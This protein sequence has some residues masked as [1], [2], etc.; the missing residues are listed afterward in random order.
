[1][2]KPCTIAFISLPLFGTSFSCAGISFPVRTTTSL[3]T[4]RTDNV[5]FLTFVSTFSRSHFANFDVNCTSS[6]SLSRSQPPSPASK[7]LDVPVTVLCHAVQVRDVEGRL[8]GD[9][10][11][12][13][14]PMV[15]VVVEELELGTVVRGHG[16]VGH[17]VVEELELG[18]VVRGHGVVGD[19]VQF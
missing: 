19:V 1:M 3:K 5:N 16:I 14:V 4:R 17:V 11:G 10:G 9:S 6:L 15:V 8:H 18:T 12:V 2:A 7:I 13:G